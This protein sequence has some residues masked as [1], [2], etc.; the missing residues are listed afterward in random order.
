M[1]QIGRRDGPRTDCGP[2]VGRK[3]K[4]M[5]QI[6]RRN[7]PRTDYGSTVGRKKSMRQIGRRD[8]PRTDCGPK[9]KVC[10]LVGAM[11]LEL[12]VGRLWANRK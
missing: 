9:E 11:G 10:E 6:G 12:I 2:T 7:G 1:W 3:K 8:G 5:R 4:S